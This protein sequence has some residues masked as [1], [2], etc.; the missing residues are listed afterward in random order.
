LGAV[1]GLLFKGFFGILAAVAGLVVVVFLVAM[2]PVGLLLLMG[3]AA[4]VAI[5]LLVGASL[6]AT[7]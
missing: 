3:I 5:K 6:G 1:L 2:V 7:A 4:V